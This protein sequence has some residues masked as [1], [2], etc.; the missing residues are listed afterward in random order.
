MVP[1]NPFS[2]AHV[3]ITQAHNPAHVNLKKI[4]I[5]KSHPTSVRQ[6]STRPIPS[7]P[8]PAS[9][10]CDARPP[11]AHLSDDRPPD[12]RPLARQPDSHPTNASPPT[13]AHSI[14]H[15]TRSPLAHCSPLAHPGDT[16]P[17]ITRLS[18]HP[19]VRRRSVCSTAV[20][21]AHPTA[22]RLSVHPPIHPPVRHLSILP[23]ARPS[24]IASAHLSIRPSINACS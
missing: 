24:V 20:S 21:F 17:L 5:I 7:H 18:F 16:F 19:S 14:F 6:I 22:I 9:L 23:P 1:L 12:A 15:L 8:Q 10:P 11:N 3:N 13:H 4:I 2:P